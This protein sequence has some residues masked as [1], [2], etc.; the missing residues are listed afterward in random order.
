MSVPNA[1]TI[2]KD[3]EKGKGNGDGKDAEAKG[4]G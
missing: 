1:T 3:F 2:V 4:Q